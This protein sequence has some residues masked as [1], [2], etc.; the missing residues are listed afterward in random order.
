MTCENVLCHCC[1]T[2]IY[3]FKCFSGADDD[4]YVDRYDCLGYGSDVDGWD[5][6]EC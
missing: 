1:R 3:L 6:R 4:A 2:E 5:E